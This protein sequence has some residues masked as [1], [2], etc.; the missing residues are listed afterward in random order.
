MIEL[1]HLR[2]FIAV[3]EELNF[4]RAAERIH[5][6]QTPLSR[7][8]RDLEERLG[9]QLLVRAPRRLALTP[10]GLQL[11]VEARKLFIRLE[12]V[13]R[14]VRR[15][16]ALHRA[17]LR[18][19]VADGIAHPMLV[20]CFT[21]WQAAV[22][23]IAL[24]LSEMP[25][26]ELAFALK[27][28][29]VDIGF[30]FGVP[31]GEAIVQVPAWRYRLMAMLPRTHELTI[32]RVVPMRELLAFPLISCS[33]ERMPGL[34]AQMRSIV[35]KHSDRTNIAG[36]ACNFQGYIVRIAAG[37]GVGL[38]DVGQAQTLHRSEIV[39]LPLVEEEHVITYVLHKQ[40]RFGTPEPVRRFLAHVSTLS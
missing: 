8:V 10:A 30:S 28:E 29:D 12:R 17:P 18:V 15:T 36:V 5:I 25:A 9:V 27:H 32:R 24:E 22:P 23:E 40:Q 13:K 14:V 11:L 20:E 4:T 3:A 7:A 2:Y 35:R 38:A 19:G 6:D 31:D 39:F 21:R 33:E 26:R 1:R 37:V 34:H 16:H